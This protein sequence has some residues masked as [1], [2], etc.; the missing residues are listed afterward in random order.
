MIAAVQIGRADWYEA[1]ARD[2]IAGLLD[3]GSFVEFLGPEQRIMSPHLAQFDLTGAFDD[4][5]AVGRGTLDGQA[6]LVAAQEGRFL[7]GAFGEVHG[8][9]LLGLLRGARERPP[10]AVLLLLDTGGVR[11]QEANA[12]EL[13]ISE[14][15]HA[16][17]NLRRSGVPVIALIGGRAGAFGGGGIITACCSRIVV[18]EHA[19][20][21][22]SGPEVI[23]TNKG[24]EEFD[25][26]DRA[27][28]WRVCGARSRYLL[29]GADGYVTGSIAAMRKAAAAMIADV[30]SFGMT[31]LQAE[32]QR[33]TDRLHRFGACRDAPEIW[34]AAG[35]PE[36]DRVGDIDDEAF[37]TMPRIAGADH[38][39]R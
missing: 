23:E 14:V 22:V 18:A 19:R 37:L 34:R 24:V 38:D 26:R 4:G 36:P 28:V 9:K 10:R 33:L 29:G 3:A 25:S 11:L 5:I 35:L 20:I 13:A 17:L 15:I 30:P 2:R 1:S 16:I 39:A 32:Q 31:M 8:A 6:V 12:G 27:L 7:G 21:S